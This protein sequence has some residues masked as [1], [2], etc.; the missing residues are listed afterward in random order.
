M[1]EGVRYAKHNDREVVS[2][3]FTLSARAYRAL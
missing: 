2:L 3:H 1:V